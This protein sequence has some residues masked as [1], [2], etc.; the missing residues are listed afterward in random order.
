MSSLANWPLSRN[1]GPVSD[2]LI[3]GLPPNGSR[4]DQVGMA[5][6]VTL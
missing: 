5:Y 4:A 6:I 2:E 3:F 1:R